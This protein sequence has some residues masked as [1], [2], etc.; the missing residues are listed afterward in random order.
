MRRKLSKLL[1]LIGRRI[2]GMRAAGWK[3]ST[4]LGIYA[5]QD[6]LS[7]GTSQRLVTMRSSRADHPLVARTHTSDGQVFYQVFARLEYSCVDDMSDVSLIID[8]GANVGYSSA[9]FLS[10]FPDAKLITV[11]PDP[12]NFKILQRNLE[13]FGSR[14][15]LIQSGIWSHS[16][17]LVI[18][19]EK[20]GDGREWAIQVRETKPGEAPQMT[21][22]DIGTLLRE[23]GKARISI[24][25]I[26]IE[27]AEAVVFSSNFESWIDKVDN[28]VIELHDEECQRIFFKAIEG[29]GF[30]ISHSGELTVCRRRNGVP[31]SS[32]AATA[33]SSQVQN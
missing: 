3:A 29:Q 20:F 7:A 9:Y 28:L 13:P 11:E 24:L 8:C 27:R 33:H 4:S 17:G 5:I 14:M 16:C 1:N 25:K 15:R 22:L 12:G 18:S 21:A 30:E 2:R 31:S 19:E 26:D 32:N 10:R 6:R 23:S